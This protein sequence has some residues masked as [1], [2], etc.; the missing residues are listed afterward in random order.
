[1]AV[2]SSSQ[3]LKGVAIFVVVAALVLPASAASE[4]VTVPPGSTEGD[5]YTEVVP[6]GGGSSTLDTGN[7]GTGG[8]H[9]VT[10][11]SQG[12]VPATQ[13]LN[14]AGPEGQK[15]ADLANSN[16]PPDVKQAQGQGQQPNPESSSSTAGEGGMGLLFVLL[17]VVTALAAIAYG[18]RRRLNPA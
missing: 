1:M 16:R 14:A 2:G 7:G 9:G 6:N 5:Q 8:S 3:R 15:A 13:A 17:L 12:V 4:R 18:V 11:G 10:G